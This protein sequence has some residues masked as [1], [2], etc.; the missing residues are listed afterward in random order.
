[1]IHC[2]VAAELTGCPGHMSFFLRMSSIASR[3]L[4]ISEETLMKFANL[5]GPEALLRCRGDFVR[6]AQGGIV[7]F[8]V[9][10]MRWLNIKSVALVQWLPDKSRPQPQ[11]DLHD[12]ACG[13]ELAVSIWLLCHIISFEHGLQNAP[14]PSWTSRW[15]IVDL[16]CENNYHWCVY[17][18]GKNSPLTL[19]FNKP[20]HIARCSPPLQWWGVVWRW[21]VPERSSQLQKCARAISSR[22]CFCRHLYII[23]TYHTIQICWNIERRTQLSNAFHGWSMLFQSFSC[24]VIYVGDW[25]YGIEGGHILL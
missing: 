23:T 20:S 21:I 12:P 14:E 11:A 10:P 4:K 3:W 15:F 9:R 7:Y 5:G 6:V 18:L 8:L 17:W 25:I 2:R 16:T 22:F 13:N 24:I 1:M 19:H